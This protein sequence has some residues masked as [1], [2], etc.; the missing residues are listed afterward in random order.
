MELLLIDSKF[1]NLF[2]INTELVN[3]RYFCLSQKSNF[4]VDVV[5]R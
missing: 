4:G 2:E 3:S 1:P 5:I